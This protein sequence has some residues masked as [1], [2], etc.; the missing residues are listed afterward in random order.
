MLFDNKWFNL[1]N[2]DNIGLDVEPTGDVK[3]VYSEVIQSVDTFVASVDRTRIRFQQIPNGILGVIET[4]QMFETVVAEVLFISFVKT[5][6]L[7]Y[8]FGREFDAY[9]A[10]NTS[11]DPI[12]H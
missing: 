2:F 6:Q 8:T 11:V 1:K 10:D 7:L 3:R 4:L 9:F 5:S 12:I